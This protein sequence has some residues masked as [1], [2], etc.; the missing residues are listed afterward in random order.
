MILQQAGKPFAG[1]GRIARQNHLLLLLLQLDD[2]VRYG[3]VYIDV[4]GPLRC[5]VAWPL[6]P[7]INDLV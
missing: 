7:E 1:A 3:F 2:M 5:E 4:L 6:D